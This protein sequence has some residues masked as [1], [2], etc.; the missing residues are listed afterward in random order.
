MK[1]LVILF[2]M[3]MVSLSISESK[4]HKFGHQ[5][6]HNRFEVDGQYGYFQSSLAPYGEWVDCNFGFAWRPFNVGRHWRPYMNGRWI[7][8][9]YGWYWASYEPFGWA[10]FHYGRWQ[11]DDY[12]GWIWIPDNVWGPAW[13][14]WRYDDSYI[15]WAPL[16]PTA[17]FDIRIGIT[18][19]RGWVAPVHYWNFV[20]C[21]NFTS[22]RIVDYVQ[23][24][25]RTRRIFNNT[26]QAATIR[27]E[28]DRI[29][30][31]GVDVGIIER[32]GNVRINQV[33]VVENNRGS[34]DKIIRKNSREHI[35]VFRPNLDNDNRRDAQQPIRKRMDHSQSDQDRVNRDL[36][37]RGAYDR[38]QHRVPS[39]EN[40]N[41]ERVRGR[42]NR[43]SSRD[44][45]SQQRQQERN[46]EPKVQRPQ[47]NK[48]TDTRKPE[49][50]QERNR[51]R[52]DK[53]TTSRGRKP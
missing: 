35:E 38:Q 25:E 23:P 37:N 49:R 3:V 31:R 21:R 43:E 40:N 16:S 39:K 18:F 33:E 1:R 50:I 51:E 27:S 28:N 20:Q 46:N 7:W 48:E 24:I 45:W 44:T 19:S 12:Y 30:N 6:G 34:G 32:R 53:R 11:Y 10:T 52:V 8:T 5:N 13:V 42:A 14:E 9:A 17:T 26:R 41:D 47:L 29:I 2:I 15:G 36:I 4:H 22:T